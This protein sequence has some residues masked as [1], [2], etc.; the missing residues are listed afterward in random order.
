[1]LKE[2]YICV[3]KGSETLRIASPIFR[4]NLYVGVLP[5]Y[6][7]TESPVNFFNVN[8]EMYPLAARANFLDAKLKAGDCMY[9]PA[10]YYV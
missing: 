10:Y 2:N 5:E 1:M 3:V 9:I 8:R 4:Q 6:P 7:K